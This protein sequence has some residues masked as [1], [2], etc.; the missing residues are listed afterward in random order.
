MAYFIFLKDQDDQTG[1]LYRIAENKFDF[2]NL[3]IDDLNY[4]IIEESQIN[5]ENVKY[6]IKS[7]EKYNGNIITYRDATYSFSNKKL[8][9]NYIS[10]T[11]LNIKNFLDNNKNDPLFN[12]WNSYYNQLD[13]LD[14]D[15]I[16][17]PLNKS[18]EQYFNEQGKLSLNT[19]QLP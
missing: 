15:S 7:V 13:T 18:L 11:K 14:I 5:F 8:L 1:S 2:D 4:K 3:N 10:S 16:D 19:L 9:L 17:Y 12:T 6:N